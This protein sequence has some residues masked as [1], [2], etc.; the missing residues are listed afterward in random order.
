MQRN[1]PLIY[2]Y[3]LKLPRKAYWTSLMPAVAHI[4]Y[5]YML[6]WRDTVRPLYAL[7]ARRAHAEVSR[8]SKSGYF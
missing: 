2:E 4:I 5:E 1:R 7:D 6:R 3:M 8:L